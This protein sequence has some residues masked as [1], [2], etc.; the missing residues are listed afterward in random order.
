MDVISDMLTRIRNA[1]RSGQKTTLVPH[2]Q[3]RHKLALLFI[4]Y[5]YLKKLETSEIGKNKKMIQIW[6]K[7]TNGEP[8]VTKIRRISKSG[9]RIYSDSERLKRIGG[10][11]GMIVVSTSKGLLPHWEAKKQKLGGEVICVVF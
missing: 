3:L 7:Y 6:L 5:G 10:N 2:S 1:Y 11:R 9:Q 8:A 4:K